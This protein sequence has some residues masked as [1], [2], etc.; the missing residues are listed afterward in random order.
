M[1]TSAVEAALHPVMF[2]Y[3]LSGILNAAYLFPIVFRAFAREPDSEIDVVHHG[4]AFYAMVGP[5]VITAILALVL[6]V[7]PDVPYG[8]LQLATDAATAITDVQP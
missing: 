8:F 5:L 7:F 4:K 1:G 6:G 2:I 3:V